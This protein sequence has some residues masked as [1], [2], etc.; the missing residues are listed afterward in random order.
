MSAAKEVL[1]M[2]RDMLQT[3]EQ[4]N[5][6]L[7]EAISKMTTCLTSIREGISSGMQI[8]PMYDKQTYRHRY[9]VTKLRVVPSGAKSNLLS[10]GA[11]I[12]KIHFLIENI[13]QKVQQHQ[14]NQ[15]NYNMNK[16]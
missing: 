5:K 3:F 13:I 4:S 8:L 10:T 11:L 1:L 16:L 12:T 9:L 6:T 2:K 15:A 14:Y 7:D